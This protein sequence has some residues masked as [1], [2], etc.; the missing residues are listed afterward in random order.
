[1]YPARR[2]CAQLVDAEAVTAIQ[3]Q[4]KH[5]TRRGNF[6]PDDSPELTVSM[7]YEELKD[8]AGQK[9][10]VRGLARPR[11][12]LPSAAH[13]IMERP[14]WTCP[15]LPAL[16]WKGSP[17]LALGCLPYYGRAR[18]DLPSAACPIMEG[19]AWTC[20]RLSVEPTALPAG[21]HSSLC[22][23]HP[24][25]RCLTARRRQLSAG[26]TSSD[27]D[28]KGNWK[29][30]SFDEWRVNSWIPRVEVKGYEE[31][32]T[33]ESQKNKANAGKMKLPVAM[34]RLR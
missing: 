24:D 26:A 9:K 21:P 3:R 15:R 8:R 23:R 4:F 22:P 18:L 33:T 5:L 14:A 1:M 13:P 10:E 11:L 16:L 31:G 27:L 12:D 34:A 32:I 28:E 19:L 7:C 2:P 20:P 30:N 29:W 17:G 25:L 6:G